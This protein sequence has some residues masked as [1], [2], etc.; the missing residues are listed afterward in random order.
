MKLHLG[1]GGNILEGW[2]NIDLKKRPGVDL[3]WDLRRGLPYQDNTV[4]FIFSEHTLEHFTLSDGQALLKECYRVLKIGGR[5][6]IGVP[7]IERAI[8]HYSKNTWKQ[9]LWIDKMK[10]ESKAQY[11][12]AY[13]HEWQ[14]KF[15]Y[16]KEELVAI[17]QRSGFS[18]A[19]C[20]PHHI[21]DCPEL[22][23]LEVHD[24][25]GTDLIVEGIKQ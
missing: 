17:L 5:V 2:I 9:E 14:H 20:Q 4:D 10:V 25:Q 24:D 6:R 12:N 1:C 15:I 7:S 11:I 18:E 19:C 23:D 13:F 16:D 8:R 21:S 3:V 22:C